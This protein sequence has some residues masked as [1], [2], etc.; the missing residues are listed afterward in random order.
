M[1]EHKEYLD[2]QIDLMLKRL[3]NQDM[4]FNTLRQTTR[5]AITKIET[6]TVVVENRL[7]ACED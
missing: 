6:R 3:E 5:N 7:T 2:Q 1:K 4:E